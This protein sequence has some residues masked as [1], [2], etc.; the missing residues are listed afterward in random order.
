MN[1]DAAYS[2][3]TGSMAALLLTI[4]SIFVLFQIRRS[5]RAG[6]AVSVPVSQMLHVLPVLQ[7]RRLAT[8]VVMAC[9]AVMRSGAVIPAAASN[10]QV[11]EVAA[12]AEEA[13]VLI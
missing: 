10:R 3:I 13:V 5:P 6:V 4:I 12:T 7:C 11:E 2:S 9:L 8:W 1:S